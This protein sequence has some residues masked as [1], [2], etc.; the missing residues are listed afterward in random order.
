MNDEIL[1][2]DHSD[3]IDQLPIKET[4]II[5]PPS[6]TSIYLKSKS[7]STAV[8]SETVITI[9][10]SNTKMFKTPKKEREEITEE[11]QSPK[12]FRS[13]LVTN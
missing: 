12:V 3:K 5:R 4:M 11:A 6:Q 10:E 2:D 7:N 8:N 1:E 9:P 13:F